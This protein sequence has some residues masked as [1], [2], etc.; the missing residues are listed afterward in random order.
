MVVDHCWQIYFFT[1]AALFIEKNDGSKK[2]FAN[3][4]ACLLF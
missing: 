3:F 2:L 1:L 4:I